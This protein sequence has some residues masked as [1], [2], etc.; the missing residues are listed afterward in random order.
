MK[1]RI[2][3][4]VIGLICLAV[5]SIAGAQQAP[6]IPAEVCQS[7]EQ[8]VARVNS[9]GVESAMRVRQEQ[10]DAALTTLSTVLKRHGMADLLTKATEFANA[11]EAMAVTDP[12]NAQ[13]G[14]LVSKKLKSGAALQ[15]VCMPY[16][17]AR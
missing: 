15:D 11:T 6:N 10:Y 12:T 14:D 1:N 13:F 16:T 5:V 2:T 7:L 8:Y 17:T 3:G 4:N 9:A